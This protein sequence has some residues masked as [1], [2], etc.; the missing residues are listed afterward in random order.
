MRVR[1]FEI[2]AEYV[3]SLGGV[4]YT[5]DLRGFYESY[6][7]LKEVIGRLADAPL[8]SNLL[9]FNCR[10]KC[11]RAC[12]EIRRERESS[13]SHEDI[14]EPVEHTLSSEHEDFAPKGQARRRRRRGLVDHAPPTTYDVWVPR[15]KRSPVRRQTTSGR[16]GGGGTAAGRWQH[17]RRHRIHRSSRIR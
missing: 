10:A 1:A 2:L 9:Q 13:Q 3:S 12:L 14:A 8:L 7:R 11:E 17:R 15:E 6:P 16:G 4:A 5:D